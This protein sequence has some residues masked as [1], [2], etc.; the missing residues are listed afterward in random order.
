MSFDILRFRGGDRPTKADQR[1]PV[2]LFLLAVAE[3]LSDARGLTF[4]LLRTRRAPEGTRR[5]D[6]ET[7]R[8]GRDEYLAMSRP[9]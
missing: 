7:K 2:A 6:G 9:G 5:Q 4:S 8:Y 1:N 3:A